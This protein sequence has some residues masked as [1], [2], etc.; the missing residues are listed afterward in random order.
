ML[1]AQLYLLNN[2]EGDN[3]INLSSNNY[4]YHRILQSILCKKKIQNWEKQKSFPSLGEFK[5][6]QIN[7]QMK[8][9][10]SKSSLDTTFDP[11]TVV[12]TMALE[13][14]MIDIYKIAEKLRILLANEHV[15]FHSF[16]K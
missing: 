4:K 15:K 12:Q 11:K 9:D 5:D 14:N 7:N 16:C 1:L 10:S 6:S 2:N 3:T 13:L 8:K